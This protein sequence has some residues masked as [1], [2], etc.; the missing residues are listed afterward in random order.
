ML[1]KPRRVRLGDERKCD[2]Q[3]PH[4]EG[5][6]Q[7]LVSGTQHVFMYGYTR[8][9]HLILLFACATRNTCSR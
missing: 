4:S 1:E 7:C 9:R 5:F 3:Y 8:R 2:S 6:C